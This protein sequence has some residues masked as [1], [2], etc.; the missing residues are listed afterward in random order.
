MWFWFRHLFEEH[1]PGMPFI[2]CGKKRDPNDPN[3]R[4]VTIKDGDP[5]GK[6]V[7]IVDDMLQ[8]GGTLTK[9]AE[10]LLR[11]GAKTMRGFCAHAVLP[12][13]AAQRFISGDRSGVFTK[14]YVT[15][16]VP[17]STAKLPADG[18]FC[19]LDLTPQI[20]KDL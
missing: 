15:N 5:T 2:V 20:L 6:N 12:G 13:T 4:T 19:V 10:E 9:C 16:S 18:V 1:L 7:L 3:K 8:S 11:A 17:R 14:L